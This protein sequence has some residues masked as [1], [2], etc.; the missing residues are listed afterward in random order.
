M[1]KK[2]KVMEKFNEDKK[3]FAIE[4]SECY[5]A[6]FGGLMN[7]RDAFI[8]SFIVFKELYNKYPKLFQRMGVEI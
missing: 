1:E 5:G 4:M 6:Q 8:I 7:L 2:K 3:I